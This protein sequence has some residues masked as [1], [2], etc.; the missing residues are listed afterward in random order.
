MPR[1][2]STVSVKSLLLDRDT[3][4]SLSLDNESK[5][6]LRLDTSLRSIIDNEVSVA[7]SVVSAN[8]EELAS[9]LILLLLQEKEGKRSGVAFKSE[10]DINTLIAELVANRNSEGLWG[11][12]GVSNTEWWVTEHV[13]KSL[14]MAVDFGYY[15]KPG[16]AG[17]L[18][19]VSSIVMDKLSDENSLKEQL[20]ITLIAKILK[21]KVDYNSIIDDIESK[22][23]LRTEDGTY[24]NQLSVNDRFRLLRLKQRCKSHIS[25]APQGVH[26]SLLRLKQ[27]CKSHISKSVINPY[28]TKDKNGFVKFTSYESDNMEP[29]QSDEVLTLTAYDVL[30]TAGDSRLSVIR[31]GLLCRLGSCNTYEKANVVLVKIADKT[32]ES[33]IDKKRTCVSSGVFDSEVSFKCRQQICD[34]SSHSSCWRND[35]T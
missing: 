30:R 4:L 3:T 20:S 11:W 13:V 29:N 16:L 25:V 22:L 15:D 21:M 33:E 5:Y 31:N 26:K 19:Q 8:N 2:A 7:G 6:A 28:Q 23:Q 10:N 18:N 12:S 17:I 1:G 32:E 14:S 35:R 27:R 24:L 34:N 9:R